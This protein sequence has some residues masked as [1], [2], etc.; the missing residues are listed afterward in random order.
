MPVKKKPSAAQLAARAKFV[1]MVRAKAA[2]K[3][4]AATK[5]VSSVKLGWDVILT[6][7]NGKKEIIDTATT[8]DGAR[9]L[10]KNYRA[11]QP[12]YKYS[13]APE[14]RAKKVGDVIVTYPSKK[15][16]EY[17]VYRNRKGEFRGSE[18]VYGVKKTAIKK[19]ASHK[20]TKSHNVNIRVLSGIGSTDSLHKEIIQT[21]NSIIGVE[22]LMLNNINN[23]KLASTQYHKLQLK[24]Q[25]IYLKQLLS[26]YKKQL[27]S[28]KKMYQKSNK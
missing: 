28:L 25:N 22:R 4:K 17:K 11:N 7:A 16:A 6:Y 13:T 20:D 15:E 24:K 23:I 5:K 1:K 18:R 21:Q 3:K 26:T 2:A 10:I 8:L 19:E 14:K 9:Q 12:Q 27:L